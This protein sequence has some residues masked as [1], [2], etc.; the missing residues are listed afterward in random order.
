MKDGV[1]TCVVA[2]S[3]HCSGSIEYDFNTGCLRAHKPDD[4]RNIRWI[5]YLFGFLKICRGM[6]RSAPVDD[7]LL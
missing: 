3:E 1:L 2:L 7:E 6:V 4:M 5:Y